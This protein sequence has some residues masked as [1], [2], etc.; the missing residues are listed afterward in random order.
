MTP[1]REAVSRRHGAALRRAFAAFLCLMSAV[2]RELDAGEAQAERADADGNLRCLAKLRLPSSAQSLPRR[3]GDFD[4]D[5]NLPPGPFK[6]TS[7]QQEAL[8][9]DVPGVVV[10]Q[11]ASAL[12]MLVLEGANGSAIS[13]S[14]MQR[15][16]DLAVDGATVFEFVE[17][18][19]PIFASQRR[20]T[21]QAS[22]SSATVPADL[23][24]LRDINVEEAWET[25]R[26]SSSVVVA[27]IDTGLDVTHPDI[28]D[29]LWTNPSEFLNGRDDDGNGIVD[30]VNGANFHNYPPS[31]N[32]QDED[33]HGT[34]VTGVI[35]GRGLPGRGM[36]GIAPRVR[37]LTCKALGLRGIGNLSNA[38]KCIDY[39]LLKG[40][41][42]IVASWGTYSYSRA[43]ETSVSEAGRKGVVFVTAAGN[44]GSDNDIRPQY[45]ASYVIRSMIAVAAVDQEG[46]L[47]NAG[48]AGI[49]AA[50]NYGRTSVGIGAPGASIYSAYKGGAYAMM[51]GTS[52]AAPQV[53]GVAALLISFYAQNRVTVRGSADNAAWVVRY[54]MDG[55]ACVDSLT[56]KV[57]SGGKLD[58]GAAMR[59]AVQSLGW[60]DRD[61]VASCWRPAEPGT[62][63]AG[64][65]LRR[66]VVVSPRGGG[67]ACPD[68][69]DGAVAPGVVPTMAVSRPPPA[70]VFNPLGFLF[71]P[72]PPPPPYPGALTSSRVDCLVG[73]WEPWSS[74]QRGP[75]PE[76]GCEKRRTRQI[77]LPPLTGGSPCPMILETLWCPP[78]MCQVELPPP[79]DTDGGDA[80]AVEEKSATPSL[81]QW[82]NFE[83]LFGRRRR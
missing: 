28:R 32:L 6:L 64:G 68:I 37:V 59:I 48:Q 33:G 25:T 34:H 70:A 40:A 61:C 31:G 20:G 12:G 30:D 73:P 19:V 14:S 54:I 53:A 71:A 51:E 56:G 9:R 43:M 4:G 80:G 1:R 38:V 75:P 42:V 3:M 78:S 7:V 81:P 29:A 13:D 8:A 79:P 63:G 16:A 41:D 57:A 22:A 15:L 62:P 17:R 52:Q 46:N 82:M 72:S 45:P 76:G 11:E 26:G 23:W 35:A 44:D 2:S 74:C 5:A 65:E 24:P 21:G 18:D 66:E 39:A 55:A 77:I 50:S 10:D 83:S 58:A 60:G 36:Q 27:V 67:A 69:D 47:W 49:A